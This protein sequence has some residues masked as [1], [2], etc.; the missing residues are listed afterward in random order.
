MFNNRVGYGEHRPRSADGGNVI[1]SESIMGQVSRREDPRFQSLRLGLIYDEV[2]SEPRII[3]HPSSNFRERNFNI[4]FSVMM[5]T[6]RFP[7][8]TMRRLDP[9]RAMRERAFIASA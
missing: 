5:P 3:H 2:Y 9:V 8:T 4:S 1:L 6:T 7:S